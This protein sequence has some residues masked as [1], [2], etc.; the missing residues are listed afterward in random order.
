MASNIIVQKGSDM[1][2]FSLQK[3]DR[4]KLYGKR[5]RLNL[6]QNGQ[7]CTR[8]ELTQDGSLLVKS[9]MTSQGYFDEDQRWIPRG[10]LIGLDTEGNQVE[11][12]PSTLGVAQDLEGPVP[13]EEV[14]DLEV[15]SVY[16][17]DA[18][19]VAPTLAEAL[20]RGDV[21][22]FRFNFRAD[23]HAESAYLLKN[24]E[25]LFALVGSPAAPE[26][27]ELERVAV[28]S[29]EA[30]SVLDDDLDFDMF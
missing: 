30:D 14:L 27:C 13:A 9:G 11:K 28:D 22:R 18:V 16:M 24:S 25:G 3:L 20:D 1:S 26:W 19:E 8:A 23:Y 6:D 12:A 2:E 7:P 29:P 10:E 5:R 17:L 4:A 15:A 21:F